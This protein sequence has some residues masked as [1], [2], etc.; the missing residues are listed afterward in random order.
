MSR[1]TAEKYSQ[2][3][4]KL[5]ESFTTLVDELS[6]LSMDQINL[7]PFEGSWTA[8]QVGDH[9]YKSYDAVGV[10]LGNTK[11]ADRAPDQKAHEIEEIFLNFSTKLKSPEFILPQ[12][13]PINKDTLI[14]GILKRTGEILQVAGSEDLDLLCTDFEFPQSGALTR[15]EWL[16]F[17]NAHT[18]RHNRQIVNIKKALG[19]R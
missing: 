1:T 7:V 10:L 15:L 8:A 13:T 19:H 5:R 3:A 4:T 11:I 12:I 9:L 18:V 16:V 6:S 14:E 2:I 17:F